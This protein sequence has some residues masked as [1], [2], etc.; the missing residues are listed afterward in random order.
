MAVRTRQV[1]IY[2]CDSPYCRNELVVHDPGDA[3]S[4]ETVKL[5]QGFHGSV[6]AVS[7]G[8]TVAAA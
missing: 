7:D 4:P 5:P 8:G 6:T 1:T 2:T 3:D